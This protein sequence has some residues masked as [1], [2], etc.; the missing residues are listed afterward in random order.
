MRRIGERAEILFDS[1]DLEILN[2][3]NEDRNNEGVGVLDLVNKLDIKHNS[4]KPHLDKLVTLN[5]IFVFKDENGKIRITSQIINNEKI[6]RDFREE[7]FAQ[8][9][10]E[11][12]K[13]QRILIKYLKKAKRQQEQINKIDLRKKNDFGRVDYALESARI[14]RNEE[15]ADAVIKEREELSK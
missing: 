6:F 8:I 1:I 4:L 5:L 12:A 15:I 14:K 7:D 2:I 11:E 10:K 9:Y 3:L 13:E